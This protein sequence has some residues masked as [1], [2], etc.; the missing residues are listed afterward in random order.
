M[1]SLLRGIYYQIRKIMKM[2]NNLMVVIF[3][4]FPICVKIGFINS[5][6]R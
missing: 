2:Q 3:K 5:E 6:Y 4:F 1:K